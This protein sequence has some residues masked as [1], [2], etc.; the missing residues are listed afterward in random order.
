[1]ITSVPNFNFLAQ[2]VTEIW[3]GSQNKSGR[4]WSPQTPF[5]PSF[6]TLGH[7]RTVAP[8]SCDRVLTHDWTP[9]WRL[10]ECRRRSAWSRSDVDDPTVSSIQLAGAFRA[11]RPLSVKLLY[12]GIVPVN[13]YQHTKFQLSS[14]ISFGDVTGI[15]KWKVGAPS[16]QF[17]YRDL[18][19]IN[20]YKC[21]KFQVPSSISYGDMEG[22]PK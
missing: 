8:I 18:V 16:G 21:A 15:P 11:R 5:L 17:L 19:C 13:A 6:R 12:V 9:W 4:C 14:S 22:V 10:M 2:L 3:R 20:A 1:M 7:Q